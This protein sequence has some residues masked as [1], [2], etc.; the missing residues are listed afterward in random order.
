MAMQS[1]T[2]DVPLPAGEHDGNRE[3]GNGGGRGKGGDRKRSFFFLL[4]KH[5]WAVR[6]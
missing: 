6:L 5:I 1:P 3:H 2:L 4:K